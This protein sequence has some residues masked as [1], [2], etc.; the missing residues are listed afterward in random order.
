MFTY[1]SVQK[2]VVMT[3]EG[4]EVKTTKVNVN[5]GRGTKSVIL[6]KNGTV[7]AKHHPLNKKEIMN[8]RNHKFMPNLFTPLTKTLRSAMRPLAE[9]Q[10]MRPFN[11]TIKKTKKKGRNA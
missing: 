11:K 9:R 7:K 6:K 8:I 4:K 2:H 1:A 3:P 10:A 5:N